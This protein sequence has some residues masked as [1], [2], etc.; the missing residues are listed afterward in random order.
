MVIEDTVLFDKLAEQV[1]NKYA[2]VKL[3]ASKARRLG[4]SFKDYR[5]FEAKLIQW[6]LTGECP[7]TEAQMQSKRI[8][9]N[10]DELDEVLC[11]VSDREV[12]DEVRRCYIKS[13]RN[14]ELYTCE[15]EDMSYGKVTRVNV[16]LRIAWLSNLEEKENN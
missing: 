16:L 3:I 15:R 14:K 4:K 11:W 13:I 8:L 9:N 12:S 6:V 10:R 7:Y 5:L 2:A 1:G